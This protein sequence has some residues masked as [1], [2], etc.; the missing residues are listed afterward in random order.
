MS[1]KKRKGDPKRWRAFK[2]AV[3]HETKSGTI[4]YQAQGP[5]SWEK[6]LRALAVKVGGKGA[7]IALG[8][9]AAIA[10]G[11][12]RNVPGAGDVRA[13]DI[14]PGRQTNVPGTEKKP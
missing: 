14:L 1:T 5:K 8:I 12:N 2:G 6:E 13:V 7:P 9:R 11:L 3:S 10:R 4:K